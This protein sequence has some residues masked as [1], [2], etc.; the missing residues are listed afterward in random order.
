MIINQD[1]KDQLAAMHGQGRFVRGSKILSTITPFLKKYQPTI[2]SSLTINE[3][4]SRGRIFG[5]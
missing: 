2:D 3:N 5:L 1:Y 4:D